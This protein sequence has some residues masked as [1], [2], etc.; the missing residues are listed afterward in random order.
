M[1][2]HY[3]KVKEALQAITTMYSEDKSVNEIIL[4]IK[5]RFGFGKKIVLDHI[6]LLDKIAEESQKTE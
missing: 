4:H 1:T 2:Q 6:N 3:E 5:M